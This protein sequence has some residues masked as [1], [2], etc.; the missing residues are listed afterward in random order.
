MSVTIPKKADEYLT[1]SSESE[2]DDS[3]DSKERSKFSKSHMYSKVGYTCHLC[4]TIF[5]EHELLNEHMILHRNNCLIETKV[6]NK[7]K[8]KTKVFTCQTCNKRLSTWQSLQQHT[9]IHNNEKPHV[10]S[11]CNKDFRHL[12]NFRMHLQ[13]HSEEQS[14]FKEREILK[15]KGKLDKSV[16]RAVDFGRL[17]GPLFMKETLLNQKNKEVEVKKIMQSRS[18]LPSRDIY[19]K[20]SFDKPI[21]KVRDNTKENKIIFKKNS[22]VK[23]KIKDELEDDIIPLKTFNNVENIV[24]NAARFI[25][26]LDNLDP[27]QLKRKIKTPDISIDKPLE[28]KRRIVP[29]PT[30][31][32]QRVKLDQIENIIMD[33]TCSDYD[34]DD[35][36]YSTA[37]QTK[38]NLFNN[39]EE[40]YMRYNC[41]DYDNEEERKGKTEKWDTAKANSM[42]KESLHGTLTDNE[43]FELLND[44]RETISDHPQRDY[45]S[46]L[47][48]NAQRIFKQESENAK[49]LKFNIKITAKSNSCTAERK[50]I[51]QKSSNV[52]LLQ[53]DS[54]SQNSVVKLTNSTSSSSECDFSCTEKPRI[55]EIE[56]TVINGIASDLNQL[57]ET[58]S[59]TWFDSNDIENECEK[60]DNFDSA[61][62]KV[63]VRR[64]I[65]MKKRAAQNN[66]KLENKYLL[67]PL[68]WRKAL[69]RAKQN[70]IEANLEVPMMN[71]K[72]LLTKR[73]DN[74]TGKSDDRR[75]NDPTKLQIRAENKLKCVL[76]KARM[77]SDLNNLDLIG[78]L[79]WKRTLKLAGIRNSN[80]LKTLFDEEQSPSLTEIQFVDENE[81]NEKPFN[82]I[83]SQANKK[84]STDDIV[85][86]DSTTLFQTR[87][88]NEEYD[89]KNMQLNE[90][91][92]VTDEMFNDDLEK[93]NYKSSVSK[94]DSQSEDIYSNSIKRI[95]NSA[96][97]CVINIETNETPSNFKNN[98]KV[99]SI[100]YD[101]LTK[102]R[103]CFINSEGDKVRAI[104]ENSLVNEKKCEKYEK[105]EEIIFKENHENIKN[106]NQ[107]WNEKKSLSNNKA[108]ELETNNKSEMEQLKKQDSKLSTRLTERFKTDVTDV[109][110]TC[111]DSFSDSNNEEES[112][113][114]VETGV[115]SNNIILNVDGDFQLL[116]SDHDKS[117][118]GSN[119]VLVSDETGVMQYVVNVQEENYGNFKLISN[120]NDEQFAYALQFDGENYTAVQFVQGNMELENEKSENHQDLKE[121]KMNSVSVSVNDHNHIG[122]ELSHFLNLG[123]ST[124][125][126]NEN[127]D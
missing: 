7:I 10:C 80:D 52:V 27:N 13:K 44:D 25:V 33:V 16:V 66:G 38:I 56:S 68:F 4:N 2:R 125:T 118:D 37:N 83:F 1:L 99:D 58:T 98:V 120:A 93:S 54:F 115:D 82:E 21:I 69:H 50:E 100:L 104:F 88:T 116:A 5:Q 103:S 119:Y 81:L 122:K 34:M 60:Y 86:T 112:N 87:Y 76:D 49:N 28:K 126:K 84:S 15:N 32:N 17:V 3:S 48:N 107:E 113:V 12:S 42:N 45:M 47:R 8:P 91:N 39:D 95:H 121:D 31:K 111:S 18:L 41:I 101:S 43:L 51:K 97:K 11:I 114:S 89:N 90:K 96:S 29:F 74:R 65:L 123:Y 9:M 71:S 55:T 70:Q 108:V 26:K 75:T 62:H 127:H 20:L 53:C 77:M 105:Y 106:N 22:D 85:E 46:E 109:S 94:S 63:A 59:I 19:S 23:E 57:K 72:S 61:F 102:P 110:R 117:V 73:F 35:T 36:K 78:P 67:G 124:L 64:L 40:D 14:H 92:I 24:M 79:F 6:Q 30:Q